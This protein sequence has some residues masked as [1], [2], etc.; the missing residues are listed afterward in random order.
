MI[1]RKNAALAHF[2][3]QESRPVC[4]LSPPRAHLYDMRLRCRAGIHGE[5]TEFGLDSRK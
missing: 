2:F 1:S 3:A 4:N 5:L